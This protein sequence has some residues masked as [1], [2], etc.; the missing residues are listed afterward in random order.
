MKGRMPRLSVLAGGL[1]LVGCSS[2]LDGTFQ[3]IHV[4]SNPSGAACDFIREGV[5]I[6]RVTKTPEIVTIKKAKHD[7]KIECKL[8][9]YGE[10]HYLNKSETAGAAFVNIPAGGGIGWIL[11]TLVGADNKYTSPVHISLSPLPTK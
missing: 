2:I 11:D 7:I 4:I 3:E 10:A 1:F 6:A 8:K 9:D 5:T